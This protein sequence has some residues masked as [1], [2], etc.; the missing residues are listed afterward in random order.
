MNKVHEQNH[1][2][3]QLIADLVKECIT[4]W[5]DPKSYI[6]QLDDMFNSWLTD[7]QFCGDGEYRSNVL[8]TYRHLQKL[9]LGLQ[10]IED[11]KQKPE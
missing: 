2:L 9:L 5:D 7:P 11:N 4:S 1:E 3:N 6:S 10:E 8:Y